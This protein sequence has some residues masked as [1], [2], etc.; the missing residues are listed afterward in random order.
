MIQFT[1]KSI[2]E[3]A[4]Q[5]VTT[6]REASYG[7]PENN[8]SIAANLWNPYISSLRERGINEIRPHDVGILLGLLKISRI[9]SGQVKEDNYIDLA[10]YAACAGEIAGEAERAVGMTAEEA[11]KLSDR[12]QRIVKTEP[13]TYRDKVAEL[14]PDQLPY[15]ACNGGEWC[16]SRYF[17]LN[18][19]Y[20]SCDTDCKKCYSKPYRNDE[21]IYGK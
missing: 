10:G 8:F 16:P 12:L 7:T 2:L 20:L 19:I 6:D 17:E 3:G 15:L 4:M 5:C 14:W 21:I 9:A 1:R 18:R 11:A 13:I